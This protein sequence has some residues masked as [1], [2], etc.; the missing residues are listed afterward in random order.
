MNALGAWVG[1]LC[2][3]VPPQRSQILPVLAPISSAQLLE[4][5]YHTPFPLAVEV[6]VEWWL[7]ALAKAWVKLSL[8]AFMAVPSFKSMGG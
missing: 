2:R 1:I 3:G 5:Q 4:Q 7:P 8:F 6:I